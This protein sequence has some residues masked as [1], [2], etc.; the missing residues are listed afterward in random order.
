MAI[1]MATARLPAMALPRVR[2][3]DN[4]EAGLWTRRGLSEIT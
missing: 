3:G 4:D 1:A 2:A